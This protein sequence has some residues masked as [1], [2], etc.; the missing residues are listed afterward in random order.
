MEEQVPTFEPE[1]LLKMYEHRLQEQT[2]VIFAL[3]AKMGG[4][5]VITREDLESYS[6]FNTVTANAGKDEELILQLAYED[7]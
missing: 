2:A 7:R 3:V 6:D 5:A 1:E 4:T